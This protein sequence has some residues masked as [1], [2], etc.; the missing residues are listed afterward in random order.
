M[1]VTIKELSDITGISIHTMYSWKYRESLPEGL[2]K[3][4]I[5]GKGTVF[6]VTNKYEHFEKVRDAKKRQ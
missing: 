6:R 5:G 1:F 2:E 4:D 3:T